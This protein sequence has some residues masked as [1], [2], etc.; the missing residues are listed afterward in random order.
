MEIQRRRTAHGLPDVDSFDRVEKSCMVRVREGGRPGSC[1]ISSPGPHQV[2]TAIRQALGHARAAEPVQVP[3]L[4][5]KDCPAPSFEAPYDRRLSEL[6]E[7]AARRLLAQHCGDDEAAI[8]EWSEARV[9][10][11]NNHGLR[12]S[13]RVTAVT[14]QVR[15][16]DGAGAGFFTQSTRN[17]AQL[18][19]EKSIGRARRRR[20]HGARESA[21][22]PPKLPTPILLS[23]DA[24]I[25][26][27]NQLNLYALAGHK[28]LDGTSFLRE[29]MGVQVFDRC[30]NLVDDGTEKRGMPFPFDLEGRTKM[31][32]PVVDRGVPKTPM[33]DTRTAFHLGLDPTGHCVG[34]EECYGLNLLME[35]GKLSDDEL[36]RTVEGGLFIGR[37]E[38]VEVFDPG[39]MLLRT[40]CRGVRRVSQGALGAAVPELVW[41]DSLLR[42]FSNFLGLGQELVTRATHDGVLGGI[43]APA[44]A[45]SEV[46]DL[47]FR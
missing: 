13:A 4:P 30:L 45:I 18:D 8:L 42:V 24:T 43:T 15:S 7:E 6:D 9:V 35:P 33:L 46:A 44:V 16:G 10:I 29:H 26:L 31:R 34:G 23:P 21:L 22:T 28:V 27:V 2:A 25:E 37:L 12:R 14:L 5:G 32:V 36:L 38:N 3:P 47:R 40:R 19:I 11:R 1:R 39:R 20:A 17:L 41:E